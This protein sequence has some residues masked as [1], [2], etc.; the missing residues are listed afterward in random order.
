MED[1]NLDLT[2]MNDLNHQIDFFQMPDYLQIQMARQN[3]SESIADSRISDSSNEI[4]TSDQIPLSSVKNGVCPIC[5]KEFK[6]NSTALRHFKNAHCSKK[7]CPYCY[8]RL[9]IFG[10]PDI[11]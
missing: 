1:L 11:M 3:S 9:R 6:D 4:I 7:P 8:R 5:V 10:R 2:D